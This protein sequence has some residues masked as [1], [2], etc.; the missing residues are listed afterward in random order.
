MQPRGPA[1]KIRSLWF[2]QSFQSMSVTETGRGWEEQIGELTFIV[3]TYFNK[4]FCKY[5]DKTTTY[6]PKREITISDYS[7]YRD[8]MVYQ[9]TGTH[10]EY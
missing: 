8:K 10:F 6:E 4:I 2:T 1:V 9:I 3:D 7:N 5:K